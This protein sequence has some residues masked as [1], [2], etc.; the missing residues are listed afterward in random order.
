[1]VAGAELI[2]QGEVVRLLQEN[3]D[4]EKRTA[5]LAERV[6]LTLVY[7]AE[8]AGAGGGAGDSRPGC[9]TVRRS[10][11]GSTVGSGAG[12]VCGPIGMCVGE[13]GGMEAETG[14]AGAKS[15]NRSD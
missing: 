10:G 7:T 13:S 14:W 4:Q 15:R 11:A 9:A 1:M 3:L 5:V 2:G 6:A 12:D 8:G